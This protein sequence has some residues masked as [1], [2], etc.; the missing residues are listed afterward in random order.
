M[1][2]LYGAAAFLVGAG[3]SLGF[4][5]L[6]LRRMQ[7]PRRTLTS[8][9]LDLRSS[10]EQDFLG[11]LAHSAQ[12]AVQLGYSGMHWA[13]TWYGASVSGSVGAPINQALP[14][15]YCACSLR[16]P[17]VSLVVQLGLT[18]LR[19][20]A[21]LFAEQSAHVLFAVFDGA[22]ASRQLALVSTTAQRA[23]LAVFLQHDMRNL[24][25]WV[26]LLADDFDSAR[27]K[28]DLLDTAQRAQ[29]SAP[30]A[31]DRAQRIAMTI[32]KPTD[33]QDS[34][35]FT[36]SVST[37]ADWRELL[38]QEDVAQAALLHQVRIAFHQSEDVRPPVW[39]PKAWMAVV[40]NVLGNASR[41]G[42]EAMVKAVVRVQVLARPDATE[43]HFHTPGI[44]LNVPLS[45]VFEPGV[46]GAPGRSGLGMYQAR[47]YVLAEGGQLSASLID[48]ALCV[49]LCMP[50][51]NS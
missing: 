26:E 19:G 24:T 7:R 31:R 5:L 42:R 23:K 30:W 9:L 6:W 34:G 51:K 39:S 47:G 46:S 8:Q 43:V 20:E 48:N 28:E 29:R 16:Q 11:G 4:A 10:C 32:L 13:G 41:L 18:G 33:F 27:T 44:A 37:P 14:L 36:R 21:R 12:V 45:R 2:A 3:L 22:L 49:T 15:T 35:D 40:D 17:D 1:S 25:Q 50:C 38:L